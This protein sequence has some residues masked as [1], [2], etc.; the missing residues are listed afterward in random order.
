M[1]EPTHDARGTFERACDE[2]RSRI[3]STGASFAQVVA[4]GAAVRSQPEIAAEQKELRADLEFVRA[5]WR[6]AP[7]VRAA[8]SIPQCKVCVTEQPCNAFLEVASKYGVV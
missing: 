2:I 5:H 7:G 4:P 6:H 8:G 3:D 1:S